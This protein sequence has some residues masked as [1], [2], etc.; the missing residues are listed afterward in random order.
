MATPVKMYTLSTCSHCKAAKQFLRDLNVHYEYTDV[1]LLDTLE[2][3]A[4]MHEVRKINPSCSFPTIV[5]DKKVIV[6]FREREI[7]EALSQ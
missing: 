6:G 7:R 5:I 1:D 4:A 3:A 2:K